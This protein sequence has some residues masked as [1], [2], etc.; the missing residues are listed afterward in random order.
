MRMDQVERDWSHRMAVSLHL[1][2]FLWMLQEVYVDIATL[3]R[4]L[5][6]LSS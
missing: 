6:M 5:S 3:S 4:E 2:S 1:M